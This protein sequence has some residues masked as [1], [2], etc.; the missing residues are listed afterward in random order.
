MAK[1]KKQKVNAEPKSVDT[2]IKSD[3]PGNVEIITNSADSGSANIDVASGS[4][5]PVVKSTT[6]QDN[7]RNTVF[8]AINTSGNGDGGME[9]TAATGNHDNNSANTTGVMNNANTTETSVAG[10]ADVLLCFYN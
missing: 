4:I 5:D 9:A 1:N 8:D 6:T 7:A 3:S 10:V 2:G